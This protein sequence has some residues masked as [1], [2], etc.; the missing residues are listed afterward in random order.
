MDKE[1]LFNFV[2]KL[3][4]VL[5]NKIKIIAKDAE[6]VFIEIDIKRKIH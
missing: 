4:N 1:K 5:G 3:T 2:E 6:K